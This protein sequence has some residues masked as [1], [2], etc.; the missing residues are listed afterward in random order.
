M[1]LKI[2]IIYLNI[3]K[4][5]GH[6]MVAILSFRNRGTMSVEEFYICE[7]YSN[8][9]LCKIQIYDINPVNLYQF[10]TSINR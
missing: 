4:C 8:T 5:I 7:I 6:M 2:N 1:Y 10:I 3:F 9:D